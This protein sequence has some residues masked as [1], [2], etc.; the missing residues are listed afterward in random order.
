MVPRKPSPTQ[1]RQRKPPVRQAASPAR[2]RKA[3]APKPAPKVEESAETVQ[4]ARPS[5]LFRDDIWLREL[6]GA[7]D[8]ELEE[9]TRR[10][11][12]I[13]KEIRKDLIKETRELREAVA[14]S[15]GD[16][17]AKLDG[18]SSLSRA[19]EL[20]KIARRLMNFRQDGT[21]DMETLIKLRRR[22]AKSRR[23][24]EG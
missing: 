7:V 21:A 14:L 12:G 24:L 13:L 9:F 1:P 3:A 6:A 18:L 19:T 20:E 23:R 11:D 5:Q 2:V 16:G 4:P 8:S 22:M 10:L 17:V 15:V